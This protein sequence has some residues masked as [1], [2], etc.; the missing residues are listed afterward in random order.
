MKKLLITGSSGLLG[1][2]LLK[3]LKKY[4]YKIYRFKRTKNR[5]LANNKFCYNYLKKNNFYAIINLSAITDIDFC[6]KNKFLSKKVNFLLVKNLCKAIKKQNLSTYLIQLSTD[7]FYNNFKK[8]NEKIKICKNYYTRTKLLA[9]KECL[10]INSIVLR[11]NFSG[12]SLNSERNSFSDWIYKS[13]KKKK[14][15]YLSE[16]IKFSPLSIKSLCNLINMILN[17]KIKGKYNIGSKNGY[18]KYKFGIKFAK[19]LNLD[20][21]LIQKVSYKNIKFFAKRNKDM[22]MIV[23]KFQKDFNYKLPN[24]D[25][26]ILK[27]ISEYK[28]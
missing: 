17:K 14:L 4:K 5:N 12:R 24:L 13:L 19:K 10:K 21:K 16:D 8:N 11:T 28:N 22:R 20:T 2:H 15:I 1:L 27:I 23:K 7:Q 9:E 6:E 18:S 25:N 26:E 3:N